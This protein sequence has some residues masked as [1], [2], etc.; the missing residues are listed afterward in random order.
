[1]IERGDDKSSDSV[2]KPVFMKIKAEKIDFGS[3]SSLR[4]TGIIT[5]APEDIPLGS[6]HS[7]ALEENSI[8]SITKEKWLRFQL[9]KLKDACSN[10]SSRILICIFDREEAYF[11]IMKKYGY[12]VLAHLEGDVQKKKEDAVSRGNFYSSI[13]KNLKEYDTRL[14][15][16]QIVAA[17]PSFWKEEL[18]KELDDDELRKKIVPATCSS[19]GRN[20]ID[21]VMKRPE[22]RHA[23]KNERAAAEINLV[24][25]LLTEIA[26][27]GMA[28]YGMNETENAAAA[29]AVKHLLITDTLIKKSRD[30]G[31][32]G[33]IDAMMKTADSSKGEITIISHEH[34][35]GRKLDGL[36][37]VGALLR[38]KMSY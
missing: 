9:D 36:G 25:E 18:M 7:F 27:K 2:K 13:I 6:H 24:E 33:R 32:Y 38:Y 19:V 11:A 12:E 35:G 29:G 34:E 26:K 14:G 15:L 5:E 30:E 21:E 37:G 17:S 4:V 3:D 22:V 1:K 28:A 23:L 20:G 10:E 16:K 8:I 31:F